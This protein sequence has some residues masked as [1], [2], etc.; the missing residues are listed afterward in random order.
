MPARTLVADMAASTDDPKTALRR[1]ALLARRSL[2]D[3]Q[4]RAAAERVVERLAAMRPLRNARTVLLYA[5]MADELDITGVVPRLREAGIRT[6]FPRVRGERL[7]LV[8]ASDLLNLTL[9]YRGV[10]EPVGPSIGPE[11]VDVAIVP[12]V[13]FDVHGGRL[14]HGGGHY[15]RLLAAL[16]D[17]RLTIGV[18]FA[19]QVVPRVPRQEHDRSVE[20]VVTESGVHRRA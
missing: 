8:A 5:A 15:D 18:C 7:E 14:G 3:E 9:G 2:P 19:C 11:A 17:D 12:G 1:T 16:P 6:L 4:R 10:R 13:A 20:L